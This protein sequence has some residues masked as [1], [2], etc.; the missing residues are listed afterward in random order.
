MNR[1]H[2]SQRTEYFYIPPKA[3]AD[4]HA[5]MTNRDERRHLIRVLRRR[6]GDGITFVDG[7][8][9]VYDGVIEKITPDAVRIGSVTCRRDD[10]E[11]LAR[12]TLAPALIKG[13]RL[14]TVVEK[15]T[16][17]GIDEILPMRTARTI[18][19]PD[20]S[21]TRHERW[22]RIAMS[23]M[24]QSLRSRLPVVQPVLAFHEV[25]Q[26][27][28]AYD[29]ALIAWEEESID[30]LEAVLTQG[31]QPDRVLLLIGPEGGFDAEEIVAAREHRIH[32]VSFGRRRFR[33]DT[34]SIIAVTVLM[35]ALGEFQPLKRG[36]ERV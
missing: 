14:D 23:A 4:D 2:G 24:K 27:A 34:A 32:P 35:A 31:S 19:G 9:Q 3:V 13:A 17:I 16:E 33:A 29:L 36:Y 20:V 8:G 15:T 22:Q 25:I 6:T 12:V 11:P 21:T 10:T 30:G 18:V 28:A 26:R 1:G 7:E 5:L